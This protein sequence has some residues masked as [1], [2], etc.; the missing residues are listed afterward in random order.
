MGVSTVG[1]ALL[2]ACPLNVTAME[3]L[4]LTILWVSEKRRA[5][6]I[7]PQQN[8]TPKSYQNEMMLSKSPHVCSEETSKYVLHKNVPFSKGRGYSKQMEI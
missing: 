8:F 5:G 1:V 7:F 6:A 4:Q 3:P 2:G